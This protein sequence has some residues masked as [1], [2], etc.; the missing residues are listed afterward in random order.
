MGGVHVVVVV[1]VRQFSLLAQQEQVF[2]PCAYDPAHLS[3]CGCQHLSSLHL[4]K[5]ADSLTLMPSPLYPKTALSRFLSREEINQRGSSLYQ[6]ISLSLLTICK[7]EGV[8]QDPLFSTRQEE[9]T[10]TSTS[11]TALSWTLSS[12]TLADDDIKPASP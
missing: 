8:S 5:L 1:S 9:K 2:A 7:N 3:R 4:V 11:T 12:F 10:T 6:W